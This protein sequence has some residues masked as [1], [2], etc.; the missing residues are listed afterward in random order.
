MAARYLH[1]PVPFKCYST[2]STDTQKHWP[3]TWSLHTMNFISVY[4]AHPLASWLIA[5]TKHNEKK[6]KYS[7]SNCKRYWIR[8]S[9]HLFPL[10][11]YFSRPFEIGVYVCDGKR[12]GVRQRDE[13]TD[14]P[15]DK[16][17]EI[18]C[19]F[20]CSAWQ[21]LK[22]GILVDTLCSFAST[23]FG[24]K[25]EY[26]ARFV[27]CSRNHCLSSID[28]FK[29]LCVNMHCF[30]MLFPDT[31]WRDTPMDIFIVIFCSIWSPTCLPPSLAD[32]CVKTTISR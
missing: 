27:A 17:N 9:S 28:S 6:T 5:S 1:G 10:G 7:L 31:V 20:E 21:S 2:T 22:R 11:V 14:R 3:A 16:T 32:S 26:L 12:E 4:H 15:R 24:F 23:S 30:L 18:G 25:T 13:Q 19:R 8:K 29:F